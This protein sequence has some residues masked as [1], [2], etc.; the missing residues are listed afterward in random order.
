[1]AS[2][3]GFGNHEGNLIKKQKTNGNERAANRGMRKN[4]FEKTAADP[5]KPI[6]PVILAVCVDVNAANVVPARL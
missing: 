3:K 4:A 5:K 6:G 2:K 1:M